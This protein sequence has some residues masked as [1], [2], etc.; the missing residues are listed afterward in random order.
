MFLS[1]PL[2]PPVSNLP[3]SVLSCFPLCIDSNVLSSRELGLPRHRCTTSLLGLVMCQDSFK[4]L[5]PVTLQEAEEPDKRVWHLLFKLWTPFLPKRKCMPCDCRFL[6]LDLSFLSDPSTVGLL[7][8]MEHKIEITCFIFLCVC[9][10]PIP[11][12]VNFSAA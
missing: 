6:R 3:P 11:L 12:L 9:L 2:K 8:L 10:P 5:W 7:L 4:I 1:H